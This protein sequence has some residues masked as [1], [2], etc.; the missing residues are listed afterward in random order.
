LEEEF[1]GTLNAV[2]TKLTEL[3]QV[4]NGKR[5]DVSV[6]EMPVK[7]SHPFLEETLKQELKAS[8]WRFEVL[9]PSSGRG[10]LDWR[11][12][13]ATEQS[14][15]SIE[16][17]LDDGT[18]G[19]VDPATVSLDVATHLLEVALKKGKLAE[20]PKALQ[21]QEAFDQ[22]RPITVYYAVNDGHGAALPRALLRE[23]VATYCSSQTAVHE[24]GIKGYFNHIIDVLTPEMLLLPEKDSR[25]G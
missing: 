11:F 6:G 15:T 12:T 13:P 8:G 21:R 20:V 5:L 14:L 3:L 18:L 17:A 19:D 1:S 10:Y 25:R 24:A 23:H 9:V 7:K 16:E 2:A 22:V 4:S